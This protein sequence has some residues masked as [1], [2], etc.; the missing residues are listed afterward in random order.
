[1]AEE[2]EVKTANL[3]TGFELCSRKGYW[4]QQWHRHKMQP[5]DMLRRALTLALT[6]E[7]KDF[8][9]LA[10]E[11]IMELGANPGM[12]T[13]THKIYDAVVHHAALADVLVSAIRQPVGLPWGIPPP[14]SLKGLEWT[15]SALIE[16]SG[17][18]L[19]SLVLASSWNDDRQIAEKRSWHALGEA[20]V[21][22][23]P[24]T[25][26]VLVLGRHL[27]GRRHG[28]WTR[29]F[30]HPFSKELRFRK[31]N[32]SS[33]ESFN[34]K[35]EQI[36][37]EDHAEIPVGKW[38]GAMMHDNVLHEICFRI[39]IARPDPVVRKRILEMAARKIERLSR[40]MIP[41]EPSLSVCDRPPCPFRGC[42]WSEEP[43][44]PN[45]RRGFVPVESVKPL[46]ET[47]VNS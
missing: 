23:L 39:E 41:P 28:A 31:R 43:Y 5:N 40:W 8:G 32:K 42:C 21:Y 10:G 37:R 15:S 12:D 7:R 29:G 2:S 17:E 46:S 45:E 4:M 24:M 47:M 34:D 22:N 44:E 1:M 6:T 19:R 18:R 33:Y 3:L 38:L 25:M 36:W 26:I 30:L 35:W 16:P 9:E 14:E 20:S 27:G 13:T 11:T